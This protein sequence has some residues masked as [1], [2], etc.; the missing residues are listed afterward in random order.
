MNETH[1]V[2]YILNLHLFN[3]KIFFV[4]IT[5]T[6]SYFMMYCESVGSTVASLS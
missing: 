4:K 6:I 2:Y 5:R 1:L 3:N